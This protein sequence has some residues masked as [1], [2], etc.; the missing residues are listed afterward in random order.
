M[1]DVWETEEIII[2][3]TIIQ[4]IDSLQEIYM[5]SRSTEG[6]TRNEDFT[7]DYIHNAFSK[8]NLPPGGMR[9]YYKIQFIIHKKSSSGE[10]T[11]KPCVGSS[12]LSWDASKINVSSVSL[13]VFYACGTLCGAIGHISIWS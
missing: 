5:Q 6:W 13:E 1:S 3:D 8:G 7:N 12:N 9:K 2:R 11:S 4:D 10:R